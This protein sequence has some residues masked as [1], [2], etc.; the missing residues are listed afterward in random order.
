M[1]HVLTRLYLIGLLLALFSRF[2]PAAA[3]E[4]PP[5]PERP[6]LID[7][8]WVNITDWCLERVIQDDSGG[9]LAFTAL[10]AAPDG[11]L[12]AARPLT[13][14]VYALTDGD[15]D[16]LPEQAVR[17]LSG[18]MLP[19]GLAF[20][21][22]SLY[23]SGGAHLYRYE[24]GTLR[25][26]VNDLPTGAGFW[27][28]GVTVGADGRIYVAIGA[29]CDRC[30][31]DDPA[32]GAILSF[33]ADG[34]DR[35]IVATGLRQPTGLAFRDGVLWVGDT[36]RDGLD[37]TPDLDE[38]NRVTPGAHFGWPYCIGGDNQPDLAGDFD[39]ARATAPALNLPTQSTPLALAAYD[40][41]ALPAATGGLLLVQG[42]NHDR[43]ILTGYTLSLILFDASGQPLPPR[44]ILPEIPEAHRN[45]PLQKMHYQNSGFWPHRPLG[46]TVSREGWIY[47]S[48]G[49]GQIYALRPR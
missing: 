18:L 34:T 49:G 43:A 6:T 25:T 38:L 3:A 35:Q 41:D 24:N 46:V 31:P 22:D 13:G 44:I 29:E 7:P 33:A 42:G 4:M 36:V 47:I 40:S 16:G 21:G 27:T 48:V 15:G 20:V 30:V 14:E 45:T 26:L 32:R 23:I 39:C 28:G 5:C 1:N 11:T 19:N 37:D 10:V 9:E 8:P 12:Y 17:L 2:A